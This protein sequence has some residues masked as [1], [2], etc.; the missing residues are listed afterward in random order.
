NYQSSNGSANFQITPAPTTTNISCPGSV[1]YTGAPQTPCSAAATGPGL[2]TPATTLQYTSNTSVGT[3]NVSASDAGGGNYQG[4]KRVSSFQ[5]T[6]AATT[7]SVS[8][9]ASVTY[10]G[11]PVTPCTGLV[12]GPGLSQAVTPT[13]SSNTV[14]VATATVSYAGGGNYLPSAPAMANFKI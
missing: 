12:T 11:S 14:G 13:Y 9:P 6:G 3:A 4:S 2:N 7:A 5:I 10:T 8:C 1:A